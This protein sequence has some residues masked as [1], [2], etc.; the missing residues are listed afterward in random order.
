MN[1]SHIREMSAAETAEVLE[2]LS[3]KMNCVD[4][5]VLLQHAA[6]LIKSQAQRL[7]NMSEQII[8]EDRKVD[9]VNSG[10]VHSIG[11]LEGVSFGIEDDVL[12]ER[13]CNAL[14]T[15]KAVLV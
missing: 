8:R 5:E 15:I 13:V 10:V 12:Y 14:E 11:F 4:H 3:Q 7:E 9:L 2:V 1:M 6:L